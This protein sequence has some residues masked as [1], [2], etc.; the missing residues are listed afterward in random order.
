LKVEWEPNNSTVFASCS[1]DRRVR[2]WDV[3]KIGQEQKAEDAVDGPPELLVFSFNERLEMSN[4][5]FSSFMVV[6]EPRSLISVGTLKKTLS[7]PQLK[8][9]IIFYKS[10]KWYFFC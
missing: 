10:G 9:K 7:W 4:F 3:S 2:V 1:T 5:H 8:K 6:T